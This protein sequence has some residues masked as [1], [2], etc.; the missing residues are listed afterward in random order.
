MPAKKRA[1]R[2][3]GSSRQKEN[4]P[5]ISPLCHSKRSDEEQQAKASS[6][7]ALPMQQDQLQQSADTRERAAATA[8]DA[9]APRSV[10]LFCACGSTSCKL[11]NPLAADTCMLSELYG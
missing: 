10:M 9:D 11:L 6:A 8:I 1:K 7:A 3:R 5:D 2:G 4:K